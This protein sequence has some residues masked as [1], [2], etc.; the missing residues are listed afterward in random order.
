M[1]NLTVLIFMAA[2]SLAATSSYFTFFPDGHPQPSSGP[3]HGLQKFIKGDAGRV[4]YYVEM[5]EP[6]LAVH[7]ASRK[8]GFMMSAMG[9]PRKLDVKSS[10]SLSYAGKLQARQSM[11]LK[12]A[13]NVLGRSATA[14]NRYDTVLN[15]VTLYLDDAERERIANLPDVQRVVPMTIAWPQTDSGPAFV[16]APQLWDGVAGGLAT[17]GEG[18]LVGIMDTGISPLH[19]SFADIGA[20]LYDHANPHG[21]YYGD[22]E[23]AE[24]EHLCNDKLIGIVSYPDITVDFENDGLPAAGIDYNGHGTHVASTAAGNVLN[25]IPI[26]EPVTGE[27]VDFRFATISGVAPHANII[28]YQVCN[29][30]CLTNLTIES[31]E[32]AIEIGVD[33]MNYSVGGPPGDPWSDPHSLAFLNARAAG[34]H[35]ANSAGNSGPLPAT[36]GSPG[37]SPWLTAVA[38]ATHDRGISDVV[39]DNFSGGTTLPAAITGKAATGEYEAAVVD[40]DAFGNRYCDDFG[41]TDV[42]NGEIVLCERGLDIAR[43]QK[44]INV[45]NAGGGGM[46]LMNEL[47][48]PSDAPPESSRLF[49]DFHVLPAIHVGSED[50]EILREWLSDGAGHRARIN[51]SVLATDPSV[52]D[53]VVFFS[54]RGPVNPEFNFLFPHVAGPGMDIYAAFTDGGSEMDGG[55]RPYGF[56]SGT[57]MSSPHVAGGMVLLAAQHPDWTPA[58]LQSALMMTA[59]NDMTAEF[60]DE[61]EQL[62]VGPAGVYDQGAG[63]MRLD[64]ATNAG[65]LMDVTEDEYLQANPDNGGD[66]ATLNMPALLSRTCVVDCRFTRRFRAVAPATYTIGLDTAEPEFDIEA[67][68]ATFTVNAGDMQEVEFNVRYT[69]TRENE[70]LFGTIVLEPS[71]G[72]LPELH[73]P[74]VI[75]N[76]AG[77]MAASADIVLRRDADIVG[78]PGLTTRGTNALQSDFAGFGLWQP[79]PASIPGDATPDDRFDEDFTGPFHNVVVSVPPGSRLLSARTLQATAESPD[80]DLY[81]F[82]DVHLDGKPTLGG[83]EI[84]ECVS[85]NPAS[86]ESC[87]IIDPSPGQYVI[88]VHNYG[89]S[90]DGTDDHVLEV[91]LVAGAESDLTVVNPGRLDP[92]EEVIL[93]AR[94]DRAMEGD[95]EAIGMLTLGINPDAPENI[96]SMPVMLSR[97]P[98]EVQLSGPPIVALGENAAVITVNIAANFSGVARTLHIDLPL[99]LPLDIIEA[100]HDAQIG[101]GSVRWQLDRAVDAEAVSLTAVIDTSGVAEYAEFEVVAEHF[102]SVPQMATAPESTEPLVLAVAQMPVARINGDAEHV[103]DHAAGSRITLSATGSSGSS[104]DEAVTYAWRQTAGPDVA[105]ANPAAAEISVTLPESGDL[106]FE[107]VVGNEQHESAPATAT[108]HVVPAGD[109]GSSGGGA[110]MWLF[111]LLGAAA[112]RRRD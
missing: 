52:A 23:K 49:A 94:I 15:G 102:V 91:A 75:R 64:R 106:A 86:D 73:L 68:P 39:L 17:Q 104:P 41:G 20:D 58:E 59:R 87:M 72:M 54:S 33:V 37:N 22:C 99:P 13:S 62:V 111:A 110:L 95:E 70:D 34:I 105:I 21:R 16:R 36:G 93:A 30:G 48:L 24:F 61:N 25:D 71:D 107:L 46:I 84:P 101:D 65:L 18:I 81:V 90:P 82:R 2:A 100:S 112:L 40:A 51:E 92:G 27:E 83:V 38:A 9:K 29:N 14:V 77:R 89:G 67:T 66:P 12:A 5:P 78:L 19:P 50:G 79:Y 7:A 98:D 44:G 109:S 85:G 8:S 4:L 76:T 96:G 47:D 80:L 11:F 57:S 26:Y 31:L 56:L 28:S 6:P 55:T 63:S 108:I 42:F 35:I 1:R 103:A 97:G 43:V 60:L 32:H 3:E 74:V 88:S 45:R 10:A 53:L 69:G